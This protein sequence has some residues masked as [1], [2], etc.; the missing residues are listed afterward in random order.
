M[1]SISVIRIGRYEV[2]GAV[3]QFPT[4]MIGTL[5]YHARER[6]HE[7]KFYLKILNF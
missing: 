7:E 6:E 2:G 3:E 1:K 5:F 4:L